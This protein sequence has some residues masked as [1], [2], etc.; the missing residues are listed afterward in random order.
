MLFLNLHTCFA[1]HNQGHG[2]AIH[3][4]KAQAEGVKSGVPD[5]CLPVRR[6]A[7]FNGAFAGHLGLYIELKKTC[8]W[9]S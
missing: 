8:A 9:Q 5:L 2:D 4:L 7:F 1:I 6:A 3:G